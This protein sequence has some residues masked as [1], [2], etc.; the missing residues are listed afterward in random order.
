MVFSSAHGESPRPVRHVNLNAPGA[1][2]KVRANHPRHYEQIERILADLHTHGE[3]APRWI[4]TNFGATDVSFPPI[5]LVSLPPQR[6][7]AF[8]LEGVRYSAQVTLEW[9]RARIY[10][11][12]R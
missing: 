4:R 10:P 1:M 7:L 12:R 3:D 2:D 8:T 6:S 9:R 5:L 11:V